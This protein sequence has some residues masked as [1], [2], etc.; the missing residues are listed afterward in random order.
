MK[1]NY[2]PPSVNHAYI[3][4]EFKSRIREDIL[5]N[6]KKALLAFKVENPY[7]LV[8]TFYLKD[9]YLKERVDGVRRYKKINVTNRIKLLE[10]AL[11]EAIGVD[12][13]NFIIVVARKCESLELSSYTIVTFISP[14][15]EPG[16]VHGSRSP[17]PW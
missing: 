15:E 10:V 9:M 13:K 7:E 5:R 8:I 16:L 4:K 14:K 12:D 17:I 2:I 3:G 11:S 6:Y 1:F